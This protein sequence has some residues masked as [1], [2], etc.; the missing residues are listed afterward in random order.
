MQGRVFAER[1]LAP[2]PDILGED[3]DPA[4]A[5]PA[6]PARCGA[7]AGPLIKI[8]TLRAQLIDLILTFCQSQLRCLNREEEGKRGREE[9]LLRML[10][11]ALRAFWAP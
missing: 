10:T 11:T 4:R 2:G 8:L 6:R 9:Q 3:C 1:N 5:R 7:D